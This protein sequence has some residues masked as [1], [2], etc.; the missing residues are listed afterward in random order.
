MKVD[1]WKG[2]EGKYLEYNF[3]DNISECFVM[4]ILLYVCVDIKEDFMG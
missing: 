1:G 4:I 3:I 2:L